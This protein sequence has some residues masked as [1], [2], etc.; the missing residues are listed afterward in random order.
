MGRK[1]GPGVALS[2]DHD[3]RNNGDRDGKAPAGE[4]SRIVLS[5]RE[6]SG[7]GRRVGAGGGRGSRVR[8]HGHG[9][10]LRAGPGVRLTGRAGHRRLERAHL[11]RGWLLLAQRRR[12]LVSVLLLQR[13][14]GVRPPP[15]R[16]PFDP[17]PALLPALSAQ[18]VGAAGARSRG[19]AGGSRR[20][21][22]ARGP[23]AALVRTQL[24]RGAAG[25]TQLRRGAA[26]PTQLRRGAAGSCRTSPG[27]LSAGA[28]ARTRGATPVRSP[29]PRSDDG[30]R[31]AS[32]AAGAA[33]RLTR[34]PPTR[35]G[36]R[37]W[38]ARTCRCFP[39]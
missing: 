15:G 22:T 8:H 20:A 2:M 1:L 39:A 4:G 23:A 28:V 21:A 30:P 11:L 38:R 31:P 29:R 10:G 25:S 35:G 33:R 34:A 9:L 26:G 7:A 17:Q 24:R 16:D 36:A 32:L 27:R 19:G 5:S 18:R 3:P 14:V 37:R 12:R 6:S 13:W